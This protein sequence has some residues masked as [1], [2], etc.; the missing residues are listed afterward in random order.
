[1]Y[2]ISP[3]QPKRRF[4]ADAMFLLLLKERE[5]REMRNKVDKRNAVIL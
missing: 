3:L 2:N 5:C 4:P 1:M